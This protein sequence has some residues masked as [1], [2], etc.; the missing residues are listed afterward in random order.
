MGGINTYAYVEA[1]PIIFYDPYGLWP[2]GL[3]GRDKADEHGPAW[4]EYYLP[5]LSPTERDD[6]VKDILDELGWGDI[7]SANNTFGSD[8]N[9][10]TPDKL[11]D[12]TTKQ[13]DFI[14]DFMDRVDGHDK[15]KD[16]VRDKLSPQ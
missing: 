14:K 13:K 15:A 12:L 9:P 5:E 7:T 6:L 1:N 16:L 4:C 11:R 3:P 2:F 10:P 8:F